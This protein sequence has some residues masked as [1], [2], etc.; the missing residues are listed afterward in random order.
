MY[1]GCTTKF[2]WVRT[3]SCFV[4]ASFVI[5]AC[6]R[7]NEPAHAVAVTPTTPVNI[8]DKPGTVEGK[9]VGTAGPGDR[10]L[11]QGRLPGWLQ[12]ESPDHTVGWVAEQ[13]TQSL[14]GEQTGTAAPAATP[15]GRPPQPA[16]VPIDLASAKAAI[17]RATRAFN[18]CFVLVAALVLGAMFGLPPGPSGL[19]GAL[20]GVVGVEVLPAAFLEANL[21]YGSMSLAVGAGAVGGIG[22]GRAAT[23]GSVAAYAVGTGNP[24]LAAAGVLIPGAFDLYLV[25]GAVTVISVVMTTSV[26]MAFANPARREVGSWRIAGIL[27]IL[28]AGIAI[29]YVPLVWWPFPYVQAGVGLAGFVAGLGARRR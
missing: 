21:F 29:L 28:L 22:L 9:V 16:I 18:F 3:I 20:L 25:S 23:G 1:G 15:E 7:P 11:V 24:A 26:I 13:H 8:R 14:P 12:V 5:V 17:G 6:S 27:A 19:L 4:I 2:Y 10:L